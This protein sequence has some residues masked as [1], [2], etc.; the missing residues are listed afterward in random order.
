MI[1]KY[2]DAH[3]ERFLRDVHTLSKIRH[4]NIALFMGACMEPP[5]LAIVTCIRKGENLHDVMHVRGRRL[6]NSSK[7]NIAK[8]VRIFK[9]RLEFAVFE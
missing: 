8:Q 9:C 3:L 2:S 6:T 1:H 5:N 4:E 7:M